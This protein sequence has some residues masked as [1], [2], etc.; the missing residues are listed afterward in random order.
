ME[1]REKLCLNNSVNSRPSSL[2]TANPGHHLW[3][4]VENPLS[5]TDD[6]FQFVTG[7]PSG[8]DKT[9]LSYIDIEERVQDVFYVTGSGQ[10]VLPHRFHFM[11][12]NDYCMEEFFI[13]ENF[14]KVSLLRA[15]CALKPGTPR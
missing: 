7:F 11:Y 8:C 2:L 12:P 4:T 15:R 5:Y 13:D 1:T 10:L 14:S 6:D 9:S 3:N